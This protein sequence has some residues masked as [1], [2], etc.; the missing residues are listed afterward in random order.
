MAKKKK[1]KN[2]PL[3]TIA[4]VIA[5]TRREGKMPTRSFSDR[6]AKAKRDVTGRKGKYKKGDDE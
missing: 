4:E 1:K 6:K 5:T 3:P 2:Q